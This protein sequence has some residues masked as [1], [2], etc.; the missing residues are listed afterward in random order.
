VFE[1]RVL[2]KMYGRKGKK[3]KEE[4]KKCIMRGSFISTLRV[5]L[6]GRSNQKGCDRKHA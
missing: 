5:I 1:N 6:L 4:F 2:R 3:I